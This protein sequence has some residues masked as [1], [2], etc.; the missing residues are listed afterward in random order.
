M[1][2]QGIKNK[3][4]CQDNKKIKD[5]QKE[6]ST[7]VEFDPKLEISKVIR[8]IKTMDST[9]KKVQDST[10]IKI[11]GSKNHTLIKKTKDT[12]LIME[13]QKDMKKMLILM[14]EDLIKTNIQMNKMASFKL[15]S[16]NILKIISIRINKNTLKTKMMKTIMS[17]KELNFKKDHIINIHHM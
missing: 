15:N 10:Q 16:L 9:I 1:T 4:K 7:Q 14:K 3:R 5:I 2:Y 12:I 11:Q 8:I 13:T 6:V 17:L